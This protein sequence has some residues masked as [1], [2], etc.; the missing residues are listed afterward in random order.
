MKIADLTPG[1]RA[2]LKRFNLIR[3]TPCLLF[4]VWALAVNVR[5]C[6]PAE[7]QG[8]SDDAEILTLDVCPGLPPFN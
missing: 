8:A 6:L 1:H 7:K 2:N 5:L 3:W 4:L